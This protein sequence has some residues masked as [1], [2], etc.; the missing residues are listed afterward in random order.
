MDLLGRKIM[1]NNGK[2]YALFVNEVNKAI[3]KAKGHEDLV[4]YAKNLADAMKSL[5]RVTLHLLGVASRNGTE[6]FLADAVLY[7]DMFG[8]IAVSWQWLLQALAATKAMAESDSKKDADFYEGK[9]FAFRYFVG[10]ELPK[11]YALAERLM[12]DDP[13][14]VECLSAHFN[15]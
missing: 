15:D 7:L 13:V 11:I 2:A 5:E 10:Y 14:T 12:A 3:E 9:I 1:M 8:L 6:I 4:D